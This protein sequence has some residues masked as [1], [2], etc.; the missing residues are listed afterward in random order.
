M[1]KYLLDSNI[2]IQAYRMHYPFDVVPSLWNKL[3]KLSDNGVILSIDKVKKELFS[4]NDELSNWCKSSL[5]NTFFVDT[6]NC[7]NKYIDITKWAGS[8]PYY[9]PRA[10]EEFLQ[11]DLADPW[12][13]AYAMTEREHKNDCIIVTHEKS[14]PNTEKKIKIPE[15]CNQFKIRHTNLIEMFREIGETF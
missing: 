11:A 3:I 1:R 4:N 8:H 7:I 9:K 2:F 12:L 5:R 15:V 10:K 14:Q 13:V 6:E